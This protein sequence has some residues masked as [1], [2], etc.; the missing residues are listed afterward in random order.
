MDIPPPIVEPPAQAAAV[1]HTSLAARLLNVF[2]VPGEVFAEVRST[3]TTLWNWVVP[4]LCLALV[5]VVSAFIIFSQPAII[6][7][8]KETQAKRIDQQVQA[9]K[10]TRAQA[11]QAEAA[12]EKFMGPT[13]LKVFGSV[14]AVVASVMRVVWWGFILWLLAQ[15]LLKVPVPF[16]KTLEV[17]GLG[18]MINVLGGIVAMLLIVNLGRLGATPSLA[19]AVENFDDTRK[20]HLFMGAAN[21]FSFWFIGVMSVGLAKLTDV[22][23]LRAAWLVLT[24]WVLQECLFILTG[25]GQMAL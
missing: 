6:Q 22:P 14:G 3:P 16:P 5:G 23:F 2:A 15:W 12:I 1:P 8:L 7:Q 11:D 20:G 4:V 19:L 17:A 10:L 9:G 13:M 25:L 21:V 18:M 24:F